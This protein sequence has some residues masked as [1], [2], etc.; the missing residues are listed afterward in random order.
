LFSADSFSFFASLR[1]DSASSFI[2]I[3][4]VQADGVQVGWAAG[5][6]QRDQK[7]GFQLFHTIWF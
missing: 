5:N 1:P 2:R 4:W 3:S 6:R 7:N